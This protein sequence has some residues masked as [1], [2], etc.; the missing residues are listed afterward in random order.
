MNND[1]NTG[2]NFT[3]YIAGVIVWAIF[4]GLKLG[5]VL[6]ESFSWFWVWFPL[7]IMPAIDLGLTI[8]FV[9]IYFFTHLDEF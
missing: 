6:P 5:N 8:I 1:S 4:L 9:I 3:L 2:H 7:W